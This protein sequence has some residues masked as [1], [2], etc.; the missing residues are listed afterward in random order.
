[1][2]AGYKWMRLDLQDRGS[3]TQETDVQQVEAEV[4]DVSQ[5][6][7]QQVVSVRFHGL[8]REDK[9]APAE[10]FDEIWHMTKPRSGGSGWVLAGIQQVQ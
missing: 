2:H 9:A 10:A 7:E 3:N 8:I 5:E 4:L 6:P 1:M